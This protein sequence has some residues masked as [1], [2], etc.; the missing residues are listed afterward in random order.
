M[1]LNVSERCDI[2]AFYSEWFFNRIQEG[3]AYV[4]NPYFPHLVNRYQLTC[5]VVDLIVFCTKNPRPILK[6]LNDL[7][8]YHLYF[9]VTITAYQQDI[10]PHVIS[11]DQAIDS[12]IELSQT[13]SVNNV[14]WRYDPILLNDTYQLSQHLEAFE[15]IASRLCGYVDHCIISFID[16][17]PSVQKNF[18]G[19]EIDEKTQR[20]IVILLKKIADRYGIQLKTCGEAID[21]SD[22][23]MT[24]SCCI[25]QNMVEKAIGAKINLT[26]T[27]RKRTHCYCL[28][29]Y[30]IGAYDSCLHGCQYCYA[31]KDFQKAK[32][33][34]QQHDPH[35]PLL[36]GHL[37]EDDEIKDVKLT[38]FI[39]KQLSFF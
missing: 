21:L 37:K 6:R 3:Y 1:I 30:D 18:D 7:K 25:S 2:P 15:Y 4:R 8:D 12:L 31:V 17:Y 14:S 28:K 34:Y 24:K 38:S 33:L 20:Y 5:D 26:T 16:M 35:S 36:I 39:E 23:G 19:Y 11:I 9:M 32:K 22:L 29:S 27:T 10:E 13:L